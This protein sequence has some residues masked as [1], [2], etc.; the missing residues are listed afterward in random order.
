MLPGQAGKT[1]LHSEGQRRHAPAR[2][3]SAEDKLLQQ[4]VKRL[5]EAIYEQEFLSCSYGYR[6]LVGAR[7][8]V[9]ELRVKLQFGRLSPL[10]GSGH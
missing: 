6:L 4:A 2:D 3:T 10:G 5:L 1:A 9:E 8:A 7:T